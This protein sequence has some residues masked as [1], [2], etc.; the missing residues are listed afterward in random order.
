MLVRARALLAPLLVVHPSF[1]W[2]GA[3]FI[4]V[5][6]V[7][8]LLVKAGSSLA[9]SFRSV[10]QASGLRQ[11]AGSS[12]S[13]R[14][15]PLAKNE[16]G[17][18]GAAGGRDAHVQ[19]LARMLA[20]RLKR[21][22]G[23]V[24]GLA[25]AARVPPSDGGTRAGA[26]APAQDPGSTG[27][28]QGHAPLAADQRGPTVARPQPRPPPP[29]VAA[30]TSSDYNATDKERWTRWYFEAYAANARYNEHAASAMSAPPL[31]HP[32]SNSTP[33]STSWP[34]AAASSSSPLHPASLDEAPEA[35][36][37][38]TA[39]ETA[40]ADGG[41][42]WVLGTHGVEQ[43]PGAGCGRIRLSRAPAFS[44]LCLAPW[45][46]SCKGCAPTAAL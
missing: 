37:R 24:R 44:L 13:A 21:A 17:G 3:C 14:V 2:N 6:A 26:D 38:Q 5:L 4:S 1:V 30:T 42:R 20:G 9:E 15:R 46:W 40:S 41:G 25:A 43:L 45:G 28:G 12:C 19:E 27:H 11:V 10:T 7:A 23:A 36:L 34:L 22:S 8:S 18:G 31:A 39:A 33:P 35:A 32:A 16:G 29:Y